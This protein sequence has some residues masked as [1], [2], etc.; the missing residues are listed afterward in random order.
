MST[1]LTNPATGSTIT[2]QDDSQVAKYKL[3][4]WF[5]ADPDTGDV[6]SEAGSSDPAPSTGALDAPPDSTPESLKPRKSAEAPPPENQES[7]D[8]TN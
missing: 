2:L 3:Q 1:K 8:G 5:S 7:S 6:P 4:G